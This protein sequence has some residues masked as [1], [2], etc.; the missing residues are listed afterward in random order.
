[1]CAVLGWVAAGVMPALAALG[2]NTAATG[3]V[4]RDGAG[5]WRHRAAAEH[6]H[7]WFAAC[8]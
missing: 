4:G 6:Q 8:V 5:E 1:M 2:R 7:P 3:S